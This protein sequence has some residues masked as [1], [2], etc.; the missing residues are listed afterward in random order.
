[1]ED[2]L[3]QFTVS[4]DNWNAQS[5]QGDTD[6]NFEGSEGKSP[7]GGNLKNLE[8]TADASELAP[9]AWCKASPVDPEVAAD[10]QVLPVDF[11]Q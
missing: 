7:P 6:K 4:I 1:M 3:V 10:D 11:D 2:Q 5:G 8:A 9:H